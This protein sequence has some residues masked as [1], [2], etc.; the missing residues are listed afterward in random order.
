MYAISVKGSHGETL[1]FESGTPPRSGFNTVKTLER[2]KKWSTKD[3][4]L[5]VFDALLE[6][7]LK[8]TLH[9]LEKN[10]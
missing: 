8:P 1:Y 6:W 5:R 4:A 10:P 9:W 2:A 3:R 7:G